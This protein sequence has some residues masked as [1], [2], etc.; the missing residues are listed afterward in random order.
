M[1]EFGKGRD[2]LPAT[3]RLSAN[4]GQCASAS[5]KGHGLIWKVTSLESE[6]AGLLVPMTC[7]VSGEYSVPKK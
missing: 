2:R 7:D 1:A 3:L 6:T 4:A 5:W